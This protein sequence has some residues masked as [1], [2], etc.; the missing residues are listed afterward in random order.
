MRYWNLIKNISNW[1]LHIQ[2]KFRLTDADP[3]LFKTRTGIV[4]EVPRRLLHEFKEIFLE[5]AYVGPFGFR[6][7]KQPTILDIGANAG[8]FSL[9]AASRYPGAALVA[10]E[11]IPV[12]FAQLERNRELNRAV[13]MTCFQKAVFDFTGEISLTIDPRDS[14]TT[15][16]TIIKH[17]DRRNASIQVP[18]IS[19]DDLIEDLD[20]DGCDFLKMDCEGSE[21]EI[22]LNSSFSSLRRI[23][24]LAVETHRGADPSHSIATLRAHLETSGFETVADGSMLF[25]RRL[26][27]D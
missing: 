17:H 27:A 6:L 3:L 10:F 5:E 13:R 11:P 20:V 19:L 1:W 23:R 14:F 4:V 25:A 16:A 9:F 26:S 21:Y 12:N 22:L 18:S 15:A 24:Q 8:F 2:Q 7:E